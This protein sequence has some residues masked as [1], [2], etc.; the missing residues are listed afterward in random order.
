M[1]HPSLLQDARDG[2]H[3]LPGRDGGGSR[4]GRENLR[5][6]L[7]G[8]DEDDISPGF[9]LC[10]R[11]LPVPAVTHFEAQLQLLDLLEHKS[12]FTAGARADL[13]VAG[14]PAGLFQTGDPHRMLQHF[15]SRLQCDQTVPAVCLRPAEMRPAGR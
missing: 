13:G 3:H 9:V 8:V 12:I 6:R 10:S 4:Q 5:I 15:E 11:Q 2:D 7:A 1:R 14:T